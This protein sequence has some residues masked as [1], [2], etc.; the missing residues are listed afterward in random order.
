MDRSTTLLARDAAQ[1]RL[2]PAQLGRAIE[3]LAS[4]AHE[5][6]RRGGVGIL[7]PDI[8]TRFGQERLL[9]L[10]DQG[11]HVIALCVRC[12]CREQLP[13]MSY[14]LPVTIDDELLKIKHG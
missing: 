7:H 14:Y 5:I 10:F 3:Q 2:W 4:R 9:M 13:V 11:F 1:C 8:L 12:R 6:D